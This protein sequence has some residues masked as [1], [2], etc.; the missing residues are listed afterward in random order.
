MVLGFDC[1]QDDPT[2][3]DIIV[4]EAQYLEYLCNPAKRPTRWKKVMAHISDEHGGGSVELKQ[5]RG[6]GSVE[7]KQELYLEMKQELDALN[8]KIDS[9]VEEL[10][11][12]KL[13][14]QRVSTQYIVIA[15]V[16]VGVAVGCILSNIFK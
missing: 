2:T 3:C 10:W 13:Q 4:S 7:M 1:L 6:G 11:E 5:E 8:V 15:A 12:V 9:A 14:V 16:C